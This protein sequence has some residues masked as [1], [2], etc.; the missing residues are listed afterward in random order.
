MD[1]ATSRIEVW[2]EFFAPPTPEIQTVVLSEVE[3]PI[4]RAG[5][6][7]PDF[8]EQ[9]LSFGQVQ[10][11]TGKAFAD[12]SDPSAAAAGA[13][14]ISKRWQVIDGRTF[15]LEAAQYPAVQPLLEKLPETAAVIRNSKKDLLAKKAPAASRRELLAQVETSEPRS[16][17]N[18]EKILMA[19]A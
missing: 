19:S 1:P 14:A 18:G 9:S 15:L 2:T 12:D 8:T 17:N 6:V 5:M 7:E 3:D 11:G 16:K 10:L 4:A 13:V